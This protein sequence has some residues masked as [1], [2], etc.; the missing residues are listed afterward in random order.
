M[1]KKTHIIGGSIKGEK[2]FRCSTGWTDSSKR[3]LKLTKHDALA[4]VDQIR[5]TGFKHVDALEL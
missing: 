3:A 2:R 5:A 4:M 1:S